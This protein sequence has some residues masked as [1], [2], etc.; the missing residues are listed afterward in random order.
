MKEKRLLRHAETSGETGAAGR[1]GG[2]AILTDSYNYL[3]IS[4]LYQN[5]PHTS[6]GRRRHHVILPVDGHQLGPDV[7]LG[8]EHLVSG[9]GVGEDGRGHHLVPGHQGW[10]WLLAGV[11]W[12]RH[13]VCVG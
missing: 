11:T 12:L 4:Y 3:I 7:A 5:P 2:T 8:G 10:Q 6:G 9:R 1:L 13:G